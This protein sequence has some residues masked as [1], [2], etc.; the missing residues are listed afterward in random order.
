MSVQPTKVITSRVRPEG[1]LLGPA[2]SRGQEVLIGLGLLLVVGG[3]V[4]Y[5]AAPK[6]HRAWA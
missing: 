6:E 5:S 4:A 2:F 3:I 1:Q